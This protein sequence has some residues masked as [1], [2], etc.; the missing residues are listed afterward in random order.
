MESKLQLALKK[1]QY[2]SYNPEDIFP[3]KRNL[4]LNEK[5]ASIKKFLDVKVIAKNKPRAYYDQ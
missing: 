1:T 2:D 5:A 3:R 4:K